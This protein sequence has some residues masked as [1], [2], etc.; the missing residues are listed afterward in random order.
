[1]SNILL[2][3]QELLTFWF[4]S[5]NPTYDFQEFWF[6]GSKNYEIQKKY[7]QLLNTLEQYDVSNI[8]EIWN[9]SDSKQ[10]LALIILFDQI[11]RNIAR[12]ENSD[13]NS[14]SKKNDSKSMYIVKYLAKNSL[15]N[16]YPFNERM[17]LFLPFR[18]SRLT[19]NLNFVISQLDLCP[20]IE[21][22]TKMFKNF[23]LATLKD[24]SKVFDTIIDI[25][26]INSTDSTNSTDD[27]KIHP[28]YNNL[29]H[30]EICNYHTYPPYC[31]K[32]VVPN[33]QSNNLYKTIEN[34]VLSNKISNIAVS[35]SGGVDSNVM[36]FI[37]HQLKLAKKINVIVAI[38]V[39]Y[40]N[41]NVSGVERYYL[42][43][44]CQY[45]GIS[46]VVRTI[47]H[48]KKSDVFIDRS[49]YEQETKNIRFGLYKYAI[50]KYGIQGICLGHHKDDLI[51]NVFMNIMRDKDFL[52]L[53]VMSKTSFSEGVVLLRP[54][55]NHHKS[56]IY[57]FAH[58][59]SIMYF[60]DTTLDNCF[61]GA[62]RRKI[63]PEIS[64]FDPHMLQSLLSA[65]KKSDNWRLT[66]DSMLIE[67]ILETLSV[68]KGGFSICLP[69]DISKSSEVF[70]SR[71]FVKTFHMQHIKMI[72][73]RNLTSFVAWTKSKNR[74]NNFFRS[75]NGFLICNVGNK[76]Y[77]F[78]Y[79]K[80]TKKSEKNI[81]ISYHENK[82]M[83]IGF[84]NWTINIEPTIEYI[85]TPMTLDKLISGEFVYT[86]P[87]NKN[88]TLIL[89]NDLNK[90][91]FTKKL[92]KSM[93][94]L[95]KYIPKCTSYIDKCDDCHDCH[96]FVSTEFIKI[97]LNLQ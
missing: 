77:F 63:F 68:G 30:D 12:L 53:F 80:L 59:Y 45:F 90:H 71:L 25:D 17:F 94:G 2:Q 13:S 29:I 22:S 9:P 15:I 7:S 1:M 37:L 54:M 82:I 5:N 50:K 33:I 91:D 34:F 86:E 92:F 84:G 18:H 48:M 49:F 21:K 73:N 93:E 31:Y 61:R 96:D 87:L 6:D 60:K 35:L 56:D 8:N 58:K 69:N 70:W 10:T 79:S 85:R 78:F 11:T 57:D 75:S 62:I 20:Q 40:G 95:G 47:T 27:I 89:T 26:L 38:H 67:P 28:N 83:T 64:N 43:N 74:N 44:V 14:N 41:R 19:S 55:L 3:L 51:E 23:Y 16:L 39:D 76:L 66:I 24:Y 72:S 32:H 88:N 81:I 97:T 42:Q 52:D 36:L 65:G 4:P 46:F